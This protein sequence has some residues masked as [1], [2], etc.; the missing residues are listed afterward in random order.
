MQL[1]ARVWEDRNRTLVLLISGA[2][3]AIVAVVDWWT[4]PYVAF[5][6]L[7]L[8]HHIY[9]GVFCAVGLWC[10]S[11]PAALCS[12]GYS[13]SLNFPRWFV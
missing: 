4:K 5:G 9:R 1:G 13:S 12:P 2:I 10:C 8:F 7:Y 6:F 11:P 3:I